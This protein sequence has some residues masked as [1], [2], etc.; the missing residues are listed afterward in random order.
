[1][2]RPLFF[3]LPE[4]LDIPSGGNLYNAHLIGALRSQGHTVETL[5]WLDYLDARCSGRQGIYWIDTL[6]LSAYKEL[7]PV[8]APGI[9]EG[10]IVHHLESLYPPPGHSS[11]EWF[12]QH[13]KELLSRFHLFLATSQ[14]TG[15]YLVKQGLAPERIIVAPPA[16][17]FAPQEREADT[18]EVRALMV[19]NLVKRKGILPFL[20][21]LARKQQYFGSFSLTIVGSDEIEPVYAAACRD[22]VSQ[23]PALAHRV[24]FT[25]ALLPQKTHRYYRFANLFLSTAYMETYGMA[26]QE[27]RSFRLPILAL[28]GGNAKAHVR[29][30]GNGKLFEDHR[31]MAHCFTFLTSH[32]AAFVAFHDRAYQC[33]TEDHADWNIVANQL[34]SGLKAQAWNP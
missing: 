17:A 27:A 20:E 10:L 34:T 26:L 33:C 6:F 2:N 16:L 19:A 32:P 23:H 5:D 28:D 14:Y 15:E 24:F 29:T 31:G 3:V 13:E 18:H 7:P 8:D 4:I 21:A 9:E 30:G 11:D 22:F 1:M 12:V 25:G